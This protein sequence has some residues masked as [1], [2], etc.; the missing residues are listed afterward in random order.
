MT[1]M[2]RGEQTVGG[3]QDVGGVHI[4][5]MPRGLLC[6]MPCV[7]EEAPSSAV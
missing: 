6:M 7:G 4:G 1:G 2:C 3:A 5:P